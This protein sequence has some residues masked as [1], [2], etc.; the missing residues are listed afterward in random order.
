LEKYKGC[1]I[2]DI[3]PGSGM[4]SQKLHALLQPRNHVLLEPSP[5]IFQSFLDPILNTPDSKYKLV[6]KDPLKLDTYR[7]IMTDGTFPDQTLVDP[8]DPK[9]RDVNTTLL[10][11]GSLAWDPRLPGMRFDSMSKQLFH[12][13][14]TAAWGNDLFHAFG[15]VRSLLWVQTDDFDNMIAKAVNQSSKLTGVI[16]LTQDINLVATSKRDARRVGKGAVGREPQYELESMIRAL[17]SGREK[18]L[19]IPTRRQDDSHALAAAVEKRSGGT[20]IISFDDT[21]GMLWSATLA[22]KYTRGLANEAM[23]ETAA[24]E[25]QLKRDYPDLILP[26]M[27]GPGSKAQMTGTAPNSEILRF[28]AMRSAQHQHQRTKFKVE[29]VSKLGEQLYLLECKALRTAPGPRKNTLL[30]RIADLDI[31]ID[32]A[33]MGLEP[34]SKLTPHTATDDRISL[35]HSK[36]PRIQWDHRPFEA[37]VS[38]DDEAWP[39]TRLSLVSATPA[40]RPAGDVPDWHEWV[41]DF[42]SG[43]YMEPA[44]SLPAALDA[45]VHGLSSVI[46]MCPSL[47]DPDKGGRLLMK[48]FRVRM[49]TNEMIVEL[50]TA[51]KDWPFK[52]PGTDHCV[53]FRN[54][55]ARG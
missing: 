2:L 4:W 7:E 53:A 26:P 9:S 55:G 23:I 8:A 48:H 5:A 28:R 32:E 51:Y 44:R 52:S 38:H 24:K 29:E 31:E 19:V 45:M 18:G 42:M 49:L 27:F 47:H 14:S 12:H 22:G 16:E 54:K 15:P 3:N 39:K 1:D 36:I 13:F 30:K 41:I 37:L 43:L 40:L 6:V 46:P 35:R 34:N 21:L 17:Q 10:V 11:T 50:A 33:L 20:G 25:N